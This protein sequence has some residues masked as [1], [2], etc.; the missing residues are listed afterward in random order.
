MI[1]ERSTCDLYQFARV[2]FPTLDLTV[3]ERLELWLDIIAQIQEAIGFLQAC[4]IV[5]NDLDAKNILVDLLQNEE[6][7]TCS[8][9]IKIHDF[10]ESR[11]L[12][13]DKPKD[14]L[15][16]QK[17]IMKS[18]ATLPNMPRGLTRALTKRMSF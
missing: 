16:D 8:C 5:H 6:K 14:F 13:P 3:Q 15:I 4:R 18:I 10:G 7:Q 12:D 11:A 9:Q 17:E 1:S 2:I